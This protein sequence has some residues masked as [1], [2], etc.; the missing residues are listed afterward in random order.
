M[1]KPRCSG[2]RLSIRRSSSQMPPPVAGSSPARQF[3]VVDLPHPDGPSSAMN[4][5]RLTVSDT[6]CSAFM[7]PNWRL[8]RSSRS[9]RKSAAW[10]AIYVAGRIVSRARSV[11]VQS[12]PRHAPG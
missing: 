12:F 4:S 1:P 11:M 3:S 2:G 8:R 9:S 7:V 5:P 6:S 10:I